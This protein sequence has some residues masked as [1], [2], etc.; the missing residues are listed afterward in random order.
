MIVLDEFCT[1]HQIEIS[2]IHSLE[3]HGIIQTIIV[4]KK[5]YLSA[6]ELSHLERIVRLHRELDINPE[7]IDVINNLLHQ[8]EIMQNE[9]NDLRNKLR[10]F[11]E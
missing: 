7:G 3:Q 5:T 2:Y 11:E 8:M 10:F 6:D 4:D 1:S 9:I